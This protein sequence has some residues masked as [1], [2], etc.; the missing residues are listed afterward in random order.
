[1]PDLPRSYPGALDLVRCHHCHGSGQRNYEQRFGRRV[2]VV[3]RT[4]WQCS[5]TGQILAGDPLHT[6]A[7]LTLV[8]RSAPCPT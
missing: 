8:F 3:S 6:G 4:C 2:D 5:G 1:M 7:T